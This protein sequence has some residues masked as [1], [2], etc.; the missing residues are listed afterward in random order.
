MAMSC[1]C[2]CVQTCKAF[3]HQLCPRGLVHFATNWISECAISH[4]F[5]HAMYV[6]EFGSI[7]KQEGWTEGH[8]GARPP[9]QQA[10]R[11]HGWLPKT[12]LVISS[13]SIHLFKGGA[14]NINTTQQHQNIG[15]RQACLIIHSLIHVNSWHACP[16]ES[17]NKQN[18]C[19]QSEM[20]RNC[21][22]LEECED[23]VKNNEIIFYQSDFAT[24]SGTSVLPLS[25]FTITWYFQ[26]SA[27]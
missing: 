22:Y 6:C 4:M 16:C 19:K 12:L 26:S 15:K 5:P 1:I 18:S 27:V 2:L 3:P 9:T 8:H 13:T 23:M 20:S 24:S 21:W 7:C 14:A 25:N 11:P 17:R 10:F